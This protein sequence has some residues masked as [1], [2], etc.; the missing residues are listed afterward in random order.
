MPSI[1]YFLSEIDKSG[2]PSNVFSV[3]SFTNLA[4]SMGL[5]SKQTISCYL[6]TGVTFSLR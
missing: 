3:T 2:L 4:E 5:G 1:E 6:L